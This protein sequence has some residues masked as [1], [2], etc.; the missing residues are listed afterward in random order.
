[1]KVTIKVDSS[2]IKNLGDKIPLIKRKGL[3]YSAQGLLRTLQINSPIDTGLLRSWFFYE[4][5]DSEVNIRTP[6]KYA[7][8]L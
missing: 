8:Y 6:A 5:G 1:M 7:K 2:K 3:H 4:F